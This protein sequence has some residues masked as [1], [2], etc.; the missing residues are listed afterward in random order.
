[1]T[2]TETPVLFSQVVEGLVRALGSTLDE[3]AREQLKALGLDLRRVEPAYPLDV[4]TNVVR[5]G[6]ALVTPGAPVEKQMYEL[7]RRFID[8]YAETLVGQ[9]MLTLLRVLGPKRALERM[10]RNFRTG[11]N[12]TET[13]LEQTGPTSFFLWFNQVREPEFYRGMLMSG[14]GRAGAEALQVQVVR[15]E[16]PSATFAITWT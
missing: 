10:S 14:I 1:M 16:G 6:A 4:W 7:G 13:K 5:Y 9:G 3:A 2:P 15:R 11:N 8:G 12:Y